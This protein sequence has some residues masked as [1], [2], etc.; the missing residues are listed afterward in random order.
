MPN[1]A[2]NTPAPELWTGELAEDRPLVI[3][4]H[5]YASNEADLFSI[6][7]HLG[8][9]PVVVSLRA[10]NMSR[11]PFPGYAWFELQVAR[12]G[13]LLG[14]SDSDE[15]RAAAAAVDEGATI[16][17]E[18][19]LGWLDG[20]LEGGPK[21]SSV[22]LFGFSQGGIVAAQMLRMHPERFAATAMISS[23]VA[24]GLHD[25]DG[26]LADV[27]PPLFYGWGGHDEIVPAIATEYTLSWAREATT[28]TEYGEPGGGHEVTR[29]QLGALGHFFDTHLP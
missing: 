19:V 2:T 12:D 27:R 22:G 6:A 7:E 14:T 17:S 15:D 24:P 5:G 28:L 18:Y 11:T 1:D 25:G 3:C 13:T 23:M 21:P 16:A 29:A 9:R 26:K 20:L 10:P 4:L 8:E